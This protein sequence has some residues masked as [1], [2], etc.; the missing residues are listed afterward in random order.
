MIV[1]HPAPKSPMAYQLGTVEGGQWLPTPS[2]VFWGLQHGKSYQ[3]LAKK[4]HTLLQPLLLPCFL[5]SSACCPVVVVEQQQGP[6]QDPKYQ[7][8]TVQ[9]TDYSF[10]FWLKNGRL[11]GA[12]MLFFH[13][14]VCIPSW[15]NPT[16]SLQHLKNKSPTIPTLIFH[17]LLFSK[18]KMMKWTQRLLLTFSS[19][20]DA[21]QFGS[22]NS[23]SSSSGG[24]TAMGKI[25]CMALSS[26]RP[27]S[28]PLASK[29]QKL[30]MKLWCLA[31]CYL[32]LKDLRTSR[33]ISAVSVKTSKDWIL[34]KKKI[35]L[36]SLSWLQLILTV[37][38]IQAS[39]VL[40]GKFNKLALAHVQAAAP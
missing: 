17:T 10:L 32:R 38:P 27:C 6:N 5:T 7:H 23:I 4:K 40:R 11:N 1:Q 33:T 36:I 20:V 21:Q 8:L 19:P 18:N 22:W 34:Q 28:T 15:S 26:T 9:I 35:G 3:S 13:Y 37:Q 12:W 24:G 31:S 25:S 14:S 29:P 30:R 16:V 39:Y 2:P